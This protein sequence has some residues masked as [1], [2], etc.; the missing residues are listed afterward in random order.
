MAKWGLGKSIIVLSLIVV[1]LNMQIGVT[2]TTE[3]LVPATSISEAQISNGNVIATGNW[4]LSS[5]IR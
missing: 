5:N 2:S 1:L 3:P 4:T